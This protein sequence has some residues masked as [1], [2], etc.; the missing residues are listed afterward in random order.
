[1]ND[2][3]T[4]KELEPEINAMI[5]GLPSKDR[6]ALV[7]RFFNGES[8]MCIG[9]QLGLSEEATRKR[10]SRSL[11]RLQRRLANRGITTTSAF[12]T[13]ALSNNAAGAIPATLVTSISTRALEVA[14]SAVAISNLANTITMASTKTTLISTGAAILLTGVFTYVATSQYY[15]ARMRPR[16][17]SLNEVTPEIT[18]EV[19]QLEKTKES[20]PRRRVPMSEW[21]KLAGRAPTLEQLEQFVEARSRSADS[22][23]AAASFGEAGSAY[24]KEAM[25][26]FPDAT[27]VQMYALISNLKLNPDV[28][29]AWAEKL[30]RSM[31]DNAVA[32]ILAAHA[33]VG[34]DD[35][36]GSLDELRAISQQPKF[37]ALVSALESE[38]TDALLHAGFSYV[39]ARAMSI[40]RESQ[41][42]R[43]VQD[44]ARAIKKD[45]LPTLSGDALNEAVA[46]GMTLGNRLSQGDGSGPPNNELVGMTVEAMFLSAMEPDARPP[47]LEMSVAE[48]QASLRE[49]RSALMSKVTAASGMDLSLSEYELLQYLDRMQLQGEVEAFEW[50]MQRQTED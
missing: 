36:S 22:L 47:F 31:P 5:S 14:P 18:K 4:W 37:D 34:V 26:R 43:F 8:H 27:L 49:Q 29:A 9:A 33:K 7:L 30:K 1:M 32:N 28:R 6:S 39:E 44:T 13:T 24:L 35:L 3:R 11:K 16:A 46:L 25:E 21:M 42:P 12:L 10:I 50:G 17:V 48:V 19:A 23:V 45:L 20:D 15:E 2:Q 38:R 40:R 41:L